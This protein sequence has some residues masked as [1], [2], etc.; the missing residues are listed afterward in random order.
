MKIKMEVED[1]DGN[2]IDIEVTKN[3]FDI[4]FIRIDSSEIES[5]EN[6]NVYGLIHQWRIDSA[7]IKERIFGKYVSHKP[8]SFKDQL[9][10]V[11]RI[12]LEEY[13]L[14]F[15]WNTR[16]NILFEMLDDRNKQLNKGKK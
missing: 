2:V 9:N 8:I 3:L 1:I 15:N 14:D 12:L 16:L 13:E 5:R 6:V 10:L 4:S 11:S 7:N